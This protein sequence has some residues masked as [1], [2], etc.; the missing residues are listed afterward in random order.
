M[1]SIKKRILLV[2]LFV[3]IISIFLVFLFDKNDHISISTIENISSKDIES[4]KEKRV[5]QID[6]YETYYSIN[7]K[8]ILK[9]LSNG[10]VIKI[11]E[12][13]ANTDFSK[14][15]NEKNLRLSLYDV[16]LYTETIKLMG[17]D[18]EYKDQI[19]YYLESLSSD[20]GFYRSSTTEGLGL[21]HSNYLLAT[22]M[23]IEIYIS[24]GEP[25]PNAIETKKWL[26]NL[27]TELANQEDKDFISL[28]DYLVMIKNISENNNELN[29]SAEQEYK[30]LT[31]YFFENLL[32]REVK[33]IQEFNTLIDISKAF[34]INL[35]GLD[36]KFETYMISVQLAD[37]SFP[38][39]GQ[40]G[41]HSDILTTYLFIKTSNELGITI[42]NF[43][44]LNVY[45]S[46]KIIRIGT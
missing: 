33:N 8:T 5:D 12:S 7:S 26:K 17:K 23:A 27:C 34:D 41:E 16:W 20:K 18:L 37:G 36:A 46:N 9:T 22:K 25:I 40:Q 6:L 28:G 1:N 32:V 39:Y 14:I 31:E 35:T 21:E 29:I 2:I 24:Y 45:L 43:E 38:I 15:I 42:P 44:K 13:L 4:E 19:L 30:D 10:E 11:E 3:T